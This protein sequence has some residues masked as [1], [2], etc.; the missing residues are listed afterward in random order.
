MTKTSTHEL[1]RLVSSLPDME[2][3]LGEGD[4]TLKGRSCRSEYKGIA[5]E[6]RYAKQVGAIR[7]FWKTGLIM[8]L[9]GGDLARV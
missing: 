2:T 5:N 7:V 9:S 6:G 1:A 3:T 8:I 4:G